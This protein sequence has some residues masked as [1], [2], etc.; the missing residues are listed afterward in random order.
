MKLTCPSCHA[1]FHLDAGTQD[2]D[3]HRVMGILAGLPGPVGSALISYLGLFRNPSGVLGWSRVFNLVKELD[4]PIRD[5]RL[6][7]DKKTVVVTHAVWAE[8]MHHLAARPA[9]LKL[10]LKTHGYLYSIVV[11]TASALA[12]KHAAAEEQQKHTTAAGRRR[13]SGASSTASSRIGKG[14]PPALREMIGVD[15]ESTA[16]STEPG[17]AES[18]CAE[19]S[20][21]SP[22]GG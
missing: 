18:D 22:G 19:D 12:S 9:S 1:P 16:I 8:A 6:T 13:E 17:S 5:Q 11:S 15:H 3:A 2:A 4:L 14:L 10:P 21:A 20:A 7:Y